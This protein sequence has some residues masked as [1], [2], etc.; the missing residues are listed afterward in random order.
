MRQHISKVEKEIALPM[1]LESHI[2]DARIAEY[3]GI[4][5][6][7]M[8][9]LHKQFRETG[10]I[11]RRPV[12]NG[13]PRLLSSLDATVSASYYMLLHLLESYSS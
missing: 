1:S 11:V 9:G 3:T 5:P 6:R 12:V 4:R 2:S 8:R 10:E 7:M 13:R